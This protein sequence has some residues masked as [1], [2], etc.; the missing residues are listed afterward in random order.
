ML[1]FLLVV[2]SVAVYL[3]IGFH[4]GEKSVLVWLDKDNG[5][6]ASFLLFPAS[7]RKGTVGKKDESMIDGMA[8]S[9][10]QGDMFKD[11]RRGSDGATPSVVG[12]VILNSIFWPLRLAF[13]NLP[14]YLFFGPGY[15]LSRLSRWREQRNARQAE[16]SANR[17]ASERI[18][19]KM[20]RLLQEQAELDEAFRQL[21][22]EFQRRRLNNESQLQMLLADPV[23][24]GAAEEPEPEKPVPAKERVGNG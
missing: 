6:L 21:M 18:P 22:V 10:R 19:E 14:S 5:S 1:A 17:V 13:F 24:A 2:L 16:E 12:Y 3:K 9:D 4:I 11:L 7:H 23:A 20:R 8:D 15:L